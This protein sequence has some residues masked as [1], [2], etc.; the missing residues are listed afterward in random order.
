MELASLLDRLDSLDELELGQNPWENPPESIVR[1]DMPAV[2]AYFEAMYRGET[3]TI[4]RPLKVVI[5]GRETVG[6]TR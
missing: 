4:T 1:G 2:R 6:K 5:V 3:S